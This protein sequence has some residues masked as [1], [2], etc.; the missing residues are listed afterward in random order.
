MNNLYEALE[1]CLQDIELGEDIETSLL[2]YPDIADEL[3]P[4]LETSIHAKGL[5][6]S[7]PSENIMRRNR[8][9]FL[10]RAAELRQV[11]VKPS[12]TFG[13][14]SSIRRAAITLVVLAI[15]FLS[16]TGLVRASSTTLPGDNLYPVKRTCEDLALLFTFDS[17]RRNSLEVEYENER[18]EE[19]YE[20]IA[21]GRSAEVDFAGVVTQQ[22]GA[23]WRVSG[24]RV[25]VSSETDL[26]DGPVVVGDAVRV[27]GI[28]Q[29]DNSVLADRIDQLPHDANLPDLENSGE[30]SNSGSN[31]GSGS[32]NENHG[33]DNANENDSSGPGNGNDNNNDNGGNDNDNNSGPGSGD[34]NNNDGNSGPGGGNDNG[35]ETDSGSGSV[36]DD[37]NENNDEDNSGS[38]SGND[39]DGEDNSGSGGGNE[40]NE[41]DNSGPGGGGDDD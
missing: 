41:E 39:N 31:S 9:K 23:E 12:K 4:I 1:V 33:N 38:G 20:L 15:I 2:R 5:S 29:R 36:Q 28:T 37:S 40:N 11:Q 35:N 16:G 21:Q 25:I 19:L 22:N 32:G 26:H 17:L 13:W 3:R 27:F 24:I 34:D 8:A 6:A 14:F 30:G 7:V 18:L 10:Q